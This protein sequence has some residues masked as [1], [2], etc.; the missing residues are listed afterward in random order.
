MK[1]VAPGKTGEEKQV[2]KNT[3]FWPDV[4]LSDLQES[5]RTMEQSPRNACVMR[6]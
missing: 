1:F 6:R 2:I 4:D 5:I 3:Q